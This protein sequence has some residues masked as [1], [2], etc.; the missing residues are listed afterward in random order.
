MSILKNKGVIDTIYPSPNIENINYRVNNYLPASIPDI[1]NLAIELN[2]SISSSINQ[3]LPVVSSSCQNLIKNLLHYQQTEEADF[4]SLLHYHLNYCYYVFYNKR[5]SSIFTIDSRVHN[6]FQ[7]FIEETLE[8]FSIKL[9]NFQVICCNC[10]E[11]TDSDFLTV[12]L[13]LRDY[14]ANFFQQLAYNYNVQDYKRVCNEIVSLIDKV[15]DEI[16]QTYQ[17]TCLV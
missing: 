12:F 9:S 1:Y 8:A 17:K 16:G 14:L 15:S 4:I 3:I 6:D 5:N 2:K 10:P 11:I 7:H 13:G